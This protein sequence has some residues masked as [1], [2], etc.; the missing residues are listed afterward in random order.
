L[1][2]R[3]PINLPPGIDWIRIEPLRSR[4]DYSRFIQRDLHS[5][6]QTSFALLVQW[7][8]YLLAPGQWRPEFR[9]YDYI[10]APWP[11]FDDGKNVG[12]GGFSLR[13]LKLLE[14]TAQL[15][16]NFDEAEDTFICRTHREALEKDFGIQFAPEAVARCFAYERTAPNG[17]ELG[18]HGVFNLVR[19]LPRAA[20]YALA[21]SLEP[22][23][24][25]RREHRELVYFLLLR[26]RFRA[27]ALLVRQRRSG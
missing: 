16:D 12:N 20:F 7:D 15:P 17:K 22:G 10:G 11:Q 3:R 14:S 5:F 21:G 23:L 18:F 4:Q 9:D 27:L 2:D 1:S 8:G 6:V 19:L 25:G 13:S 26:G 24:L